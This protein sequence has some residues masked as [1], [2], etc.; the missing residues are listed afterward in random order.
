MTMRKEKLP[1]IKKSTNH[2]KHIFQN[3]ESKYIQVFTL[4]IK[5]KIYKGLLYS[6]K[7][8]LNLKEHHKNN[9]GF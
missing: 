2:T 1:G 9:F 4:F 6:L 3:L 8:I 7:Y 5:I